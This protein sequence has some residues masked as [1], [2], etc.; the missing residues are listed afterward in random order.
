MLKPLK[1]VP[2]TTRELKPEG[3]LR[4]QLQI[5]AEGLAGHL[6]EV[7]PDIRNSQWIGG[8]CEGWERVPYW[9]DG[10]IPLAYL[11]EDERLIAV[12]KKYIDAI[13]AQ[14]KP[15][16]WI[17]PCDDNQRHRYDLWALILIC[18]TLTV[19]AD[20]SGDE[21]R[22]YDA[23]YRALKQCF[24][25]RRRL[26]HEW[27]MTRWFEAL[28]PIAWL[29]ERND[30]EWLHEFVWRLHVQGMDYEHYLEERYG[31]PPVKH[32]RDT[33]D[34][35]THV[36]NV[37]MSLK[38]EALLARFT[39]QPLTGLAERTLEILERNH[40]MSCGHFT[41]DEC[42][43][44]TE[45]TQGTELCGVVETMYSYEQLLWMTGEAKWGDRLEKLAFNALPA[46]FT[47]DMWAHQYDQMTNQMQSTPLSWEERPFSTN[48][49][50]AHLFGL[51]PHF[52]C[53]TAN[54]GQG[55]PK[56][57]LSAFA[58]TEKGVA[59]VALIPATV[60]TTIGDAAVT[61]T[62]ETLYPFRD[63]VKY[64]V[65]TS[66]PVEFE[67]SIRVPGWAKSAKIGDKVVPAGAFAAVNRV[68]EGTTELILSLTA[69]PV[70]TARPGGLY[71]V[72]RGAL[73]YSLPIETRWE[74]WEYVKNGVERKFPYC[75]WKIYPQS[76][77]AF[78]FAADQVEYTEKAPG[79]YLFSPDGAA[80]CLRVS[81]APIEW[82]SKN[83]LCS[84]Y[85][86]SNVPTGEVR[87]MEFIPYGCTMLRMTEL[88]FAENGSCV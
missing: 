37:G 76:D 32:C 27:G 13:L 21:E 87:T 62:T 22:V 34:F 55:W 14:Q 67:L 8:D 50:E 75:D 58:R 57:A 5:Q 45:P 66:K 73:L 23:I 39:G 80:C 18:K 81:V 52:G 3:W 47:P 63:T 12:S 36:V 65:K 31:A 29:C 53:C 38:M 30:E 56:F 78:A 85:P 54:H 1:L 42:L 79:E 15:D 11:L 84:P 16:G 68:W 74:K 6:H 72:S 51:E 43:S 70:F 88:P 82:Q 10:L 59:S 4:R 17:C 69:E 35:F 44:G 46:A 2:F 64:I 7:W 24:Y 48:N 77:W 60:T 20:C 19:Y 40:G 26:M 49:G 33:W 9:L 41:G 25:F 86:V 61:C 28:I 83:G 71:N